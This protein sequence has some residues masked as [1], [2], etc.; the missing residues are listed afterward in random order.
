MDP[1]RV[2]DYNNLLLSCYFLGDLDKAMYSIIQAIELDTYNAYWCY[3]CGLIWLEYVNLKGSVSDF[4]RV[5]EIE[6]DPSSQ[7][8]F[9]RVLDQHDR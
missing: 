1:D 9:L 5:L 2:L 6:L 8:K 4:E 3:D 7:K